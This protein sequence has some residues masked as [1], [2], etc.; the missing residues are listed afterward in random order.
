MPAAG[1]PSRGRKRVNAKEP[2]PGHARM[3]GT[4]CVLQPAHTRH[5][6]ARLLD[7]SRGSPGK[8]VK[9]QSKAAEGIPVPAES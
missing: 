9:A 8:L 3:A 1:K 7:H 2:S 4:W 6:Q 5:A